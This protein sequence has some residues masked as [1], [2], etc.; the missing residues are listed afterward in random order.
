MAMAVWLQSLPFWCSV[1]SNFAYDPRYSNFHFSSS[2][3][4]ALFTDFCSS[5]FFELEC[6]NKER[7]KLK[8]SWY[9]RLQEVVNQSPKITL[10]K[11]TFGQQNFS[12]AIMCTENN[13][14]QEAN[15]QSSE[16]LLRLAFIFF[17]FTAHCVAMCVGS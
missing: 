13:K 9:S 6:K 14:I 4:T 17:T 3:E 8:L 10:A 16:M 12:I 11:Q 7:N 5:V 2:V 15:L 1:G